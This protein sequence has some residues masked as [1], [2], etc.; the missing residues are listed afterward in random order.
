MAELVAGTLNISFSASLAL[1]CRS[2]GDLNH[3]GWSDSGFP[4]STSNGFYYN[5]PFGALA[6]EEGRIVVLNYEAREQSAVGRTG[7][8]PA[9]FV[10]GLPSAQMTVAG[11]C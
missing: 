3:Y 1:K 2:W 5:E 9:A 6:S 4:F 8:A 11:C 7:S 10:L